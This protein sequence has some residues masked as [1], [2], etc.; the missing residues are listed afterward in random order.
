MMM[1]IA[2]KDRVERRRSKERRNGGRVIGGRGKM[3]RSRVGGK[4]G[5]MIEGEGRG[6]KGPR[7]YTCRSE[8]EEVEKDAKMK[9]NGKMRR[10]KRRRR[11]T[12]SVKTWMA[13]ESVFVSMF[14]AVRTCTSTRPE[15]PPTQIIPLFTK[16]IDAQHD[17]FNQ[18]NSF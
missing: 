13:E 2:L 16:K 5:R 11:K 17:C 10:R 1:M 6:T 3:Q 4:G 9:M 8:E 18:N 14:V 7:S 15:Y 12:S